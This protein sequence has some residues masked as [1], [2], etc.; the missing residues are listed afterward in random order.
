[1]PFIGAHEPLP[2]PGSPEAARP[3]AMSPMFHRLV[4]DAASVAR[5]EIA[6]ERIQAP[7]LLVS[8]E[9][10]A[11]WPSARL[12]DIAMRRM[13]ERGHAFEHRH[14]RNLGA[15]HL[16]GVPY[17]PATVHEVF[18]PIAKLRFLFGGSDA[19]DAAASVT[20]WRELL[21]F[22]EPRRAT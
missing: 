5:C 22:L 2:L 11:M 19:P 16:L 7:V 3:I 1:V 9:D 13:A 20:A 21:A 15:G 17:L 18:Q 10:D 6:V 14:V 8:C 12:S 4:D